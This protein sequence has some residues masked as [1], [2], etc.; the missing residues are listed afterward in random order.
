[1]S[2]P[3]NNLLESCGKLGLYPN[4]RLMT[5]YSFRGTSLPSCGEIIER[6]SCNQLVCCFPTC[7]YVNCKFLGEGACDMV[8]LTVQWRGD[9]TTISEV[10]V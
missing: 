3:A 6:N 7:V 1:M 2:D 8:R 5:M 10:G 9:R 4:P